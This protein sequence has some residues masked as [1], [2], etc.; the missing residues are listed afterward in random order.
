[1]TD[2]VISSCCLGIICIGW[3]ALWAFVAVNVTRY[4]WLGWYRRS[5]ERAKASLPPERGAFSD[6]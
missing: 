4:G 5:L 3:P 2:N 6:D 1:M